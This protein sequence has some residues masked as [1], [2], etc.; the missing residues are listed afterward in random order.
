MGADGGAHRAD[1]QGIREGG[2]DRLAVL[3][4]FLQRRVIQAGVAQTEGHGEVDAVGLFDLLNQ[5]VV[6]VSGAPGLAQQYHLAAG[7]GDHRLD[8]QH[9]A[10]HGGCFGDPAALAQIFQ[11]VQ[12]TYDVDLPLGCFQRMGDVLR[13]HPPIHQLHGVA[14]QDLLAQGHVAAIHHPDPVGVVR[15]GNDGALIGAGQL[16]GQG[17]HQNLFIRLRGCAEGLLKDGGGDQ[18]GG[19]KFVAFNE[20]FIELTGLQIHP[21]PVAV[22]AEGDGQGQYGNIRAGAVP[23]IRAGVGNDSDFF[24]F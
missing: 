22:L 15:G 20:L 2:P 1:G 11:G 5:V 10:Q 18:A 7:H 3:D 9:I 24:H 8:G 6:A 13:R 19:G 16:A 14:H 12:Q 23:Q 4:V 17:N 21:V